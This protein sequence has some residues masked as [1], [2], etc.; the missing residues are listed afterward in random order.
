MATLK[1]IKDRLRELNLE[2]EY[3]Y[4]KEIRLIPQALTPDESVRTMT[5]GTYDGRRW[6]VVLTGQRILF[7][8]K[9][10]LGK[11][12]LVAFDHEQVRAVKGRKGF[13]FGSLT[14]ETEQNIYIFSNILKKS[15]PRFLFEAQQVG[16]NSG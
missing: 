4:R 14:I 2:N 5:S 16:I 9:P 6:A 13:L 8:S 3:G 7:L 12:S 10:A 1:D 11:P 15:L